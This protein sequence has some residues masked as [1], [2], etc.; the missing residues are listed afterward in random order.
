M[1]IY[2]YKDS[3]DRVVYVGQTDNLIRRDSDHY[4]D[5]YW[6]FSTL[7]LE[8]IICE[9]NHADEVEAYFIKLFN[10]KHN[11]NKPECHLHSFEINSYVDSIGW[12]RFARK[13]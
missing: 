3:N 7:K 6:C 2:R 9:N 8:Y 11:K 12:R 5:D 1:Y 4:R 13:I 10:P